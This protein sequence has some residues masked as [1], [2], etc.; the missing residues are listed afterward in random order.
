MSKPPLGASVLVVAIGVCLAHCGGGVAGGAADGGGTV[1]EGGSGGGEGGLDDGG[2]TCA[3]TIHRSAAKTCAPSSPAPV[4]PEGGTPACATDADCEASGSGFTFCSQN[5]CVFD[6][7]FV[8]SDCSNG[9]LCGCSTDHYGGNALYH[10][11]VC[12]PAD[13]HVDSDCGSG[14]CAPSFG[15][16]GSYDSFH[17]SSGGAP[18]CSSTETCT[19]VPQVGHFACGPATVCNG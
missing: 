11:N 17:C 3:P 6:Q 2:A 12:V 4:A 10:P 18:A 9:G 8:D 1:G 16:C 15:I 7:C 5:H 13:C 14:L 19:Y